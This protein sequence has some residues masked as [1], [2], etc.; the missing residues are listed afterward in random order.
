MKWLKRWFG[1]MK[2][3]YYYYDEQG[4]WTEKERQEFDR[5]FAKHRELFGDV[6]KFI[7]RQSTKR[8]KK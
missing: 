6:D 3:Y 8:G 5:I 2:K 1:G 4:E 7:T